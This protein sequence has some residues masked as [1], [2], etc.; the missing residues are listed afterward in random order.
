MSI[1]RP[2][3]FRLLIVTIAA[4]AASRPSPAAAQA[5][6]TATATAQERLWDAAIAGDTVALGRALTDGAKVDS[7]DVRRSQNGRMALNWAAW[8]NHAPAI[9]FLVAHGAPVNGVNRTG[10]T[11]LHHAAENGSADAAAALLDVGADPAWPNGAG[12]TA[13]EVARERGHPAIAE[14]I[15]NSAK[16]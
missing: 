14:R 10:F 9:R 13:A 5:A 12:Q 15:E 6:T 7:L 11:A 16:R 2:T 8:H 4:M 3:R 1:F